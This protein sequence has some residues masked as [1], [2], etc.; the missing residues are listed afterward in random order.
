MRTGGTPQFPIIIY[1]PNADKDLTTSQ[2]SLKYT[3]PA[4]NG[5]L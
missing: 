2:L 3:E 5:Q 1:N 4:K